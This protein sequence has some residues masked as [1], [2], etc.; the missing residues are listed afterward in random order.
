MRK[1]QGTTQSA[2]LYSKIDQQNLRLFI[3]FGILIVF[4]PIFG[5]LKQQKISPAVKILHTF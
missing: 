2:V 1:E 4:R 5:L 3:N